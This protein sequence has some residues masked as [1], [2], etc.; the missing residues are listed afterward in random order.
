MSKQ[1]RTLAEKLRALYFVA[2]DRHDEHGNEV[3]DPTKVEMPLGFRE[4]PTIQQMLHDA[5]R[6]QAIQM[7]QA[8]R[9]E[10]TL[11]DSMDFEL[12][13]DPDFLEPTAHEYRAMQ[14]ES[15][16]K[17]G[18]RVEEALIRHRASKVALEA[19]T[20]PKAQPKATEATPPPAEA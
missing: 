18:A 19:P 20:E 2:T 3:P 14:E 15:V 9:G 11:E 4:P 7:A 6:G 1:K 13:E 8:A 5:L 16:I 10:E 17:E 12:Q